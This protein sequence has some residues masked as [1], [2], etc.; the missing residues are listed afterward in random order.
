VE[1]AAGRAAAVRKENSLPAGAGVPSDLALASGSGLDPHI[2]LESA[3]LQARRVARERNMTP[4]AVEGL[5]RK[6]AEARYFGGAGDRYLNVLLLNME[7]DSM[8]TVR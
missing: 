8:G 1:Q 4:Q 7:L 3:L 2:S 6:R 5:I